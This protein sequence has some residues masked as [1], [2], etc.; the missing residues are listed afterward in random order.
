MIAV[1]NLKTN[2]LDVEMPKQMLYTCL[3]HAWGM[4]LK[5]HHVKSERHVAYTGVP[6]MCA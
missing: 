2:L 1:A 3:I 5:Q 4:L 6:K